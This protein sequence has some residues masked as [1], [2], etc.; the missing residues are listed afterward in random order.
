MVQEP[1]G[2]VYVLF[3]KRVRVD[4]GIDISAAP[5]NQTHVSHSIQLDILALCLITYVLWDYIQKHAKNAFVRSF[6]LYNVVAPSSR[7][8]PAGCYFSAHT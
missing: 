5:S 1:E 3:V 4:S 6:V 7:L 8:C 2:Y